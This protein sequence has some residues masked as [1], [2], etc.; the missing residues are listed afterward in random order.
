[1]KP[2]DLM[3]LAWLALTLLSTGV[4][5][6]YV[7]NYSNVDVTRWK[8]FLCE[9][10][11]HSGFSGQVSATSIRTTDDSDRFG[12]DGAFERAGTGSVLDARAGVS[13]Q[14]WIVSAN[15]QNLGLDSHDMAFVANRRGKLK[16]R[17]RIQQYRN[18]VESEALT[19]FRETDS[20]WKLPSDWQSDFQTQGFLNLGS[21]N[22]VIELARTRRMVE[23]AIVL[24]VLP[25]LNV[26]FTRKASSK[27]GYQETYRDGFLQ[28]TALP[29]RIDH[30]LL[31]NQLRIAYRSDILSM[32]WTRSRSKFEN[33]A[34]LLR[35]ESPYQFGLSANESANAYAHK[36][37]SDTLDIK[38]T[39]S[40][41]GM[42][43]MHERKGKSITEPQPIRYGLSPFLDELE[44]VQV[45]AERNYRSR[46][47]QFTKQ[48]F[49][50][51]K[52]SLSRS[53]YQLEDF[54]SEDT[55]TP[56]L[57]GLFLTPPQALRAGDIERGE[58]EFGVKYRLRSGIAVATKLWMTEL[59]RRDQEIDTNKI[60]GMDWQ[61]ELPLQNR[62]KALM[63]FQNDSRDASEFQNITT[64][65]PRTR[66]FHS[67]ERD[68]RRLSGE[69]RYFVNDSASFVAMSYDAS[70][71]DYPSSVLGMSSVENRGISLKYAAS[72][73][74]RVTADAHVA[75]HQQVSQ[76]NGSQS[77]DLTMPWV[78]SSDDQVKSAGL[79]LSIMPTYESLRRIQFNYIL[80]DGEICAESL[81]QL[82]EDIFP[83]QIS[84]HES[85]DITIDAGTLLGATVET[86]IYVEKYDAMDRSIDE[87]DQATLGSVLTLGRD[88]PSYRNTLFALR[89]SK[90]FR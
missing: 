38:V 7:T 43:R 25:K 36:H 46:R 69:I 48:F 20:G 51:L 79:S 88:R 31:A 86:R 85:L 63:R 15:A 65:N 18:L 42:L 83:S 74:E 6:G 29:K 5:A 61:F 1:M 81:F 53:I 37:A 76:I 23:S 60:R 49:D 24:Q 71:Q 21:S 84:R 11:T 41:D 4:S 26:Q 13:T 8:C 82:Q 75:S 57:S 68:Q 58:T 40:D 70:K 2:A 52:F 34:P 78:Y 9:F 47:M 44:P 62:W 67:A 55:L 32:A 77:L 50:G 45:F 72:F 80:S 19:P 10:E 64:N 56:A 16:A 90:R 39:V 30:D 87:I 66:R 28:T 33:L 3:R 59:N 22:Q 14:G 73:S 35:W 12:R 17:L 89:L 27:E 54:R